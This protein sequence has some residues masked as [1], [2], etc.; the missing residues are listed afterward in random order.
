MD[1]HPKFSTWLAAAQI[2]PGNES[3]RKY[4]AG[5]SEFAVDRATIISLTRVA[6]RLEPEPAFEAKLVAAIHAQDAAFVP[7]PIVLAA[8]AATRL[9]ITLDQE[10]EPLDTLAALAIVCASES[11]H[12]Q[13]LFLDDLSATAESVVHFRSEHRGDWDYLRTGAT[14]DGAEEIEVLRRVVAVTA[15][16]ANILWWIFGETSRD[17]KRRF[18]ALS[19]ELIPFVAGK[20]LA[21][22]TVLI[23]GPLAIGAFADRVWRHGRATLTEQLSV[24]ASIASLPT[25]WRDKLV[26]R[27]KDKPVL[28]LAPIAKAITASAMANGTQWP[29]A[30]TKSTGWQK[31]QKFSSVQLALLTYR[32]SLLL[33]AWNQSAS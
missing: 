18:E 20:E 28:A 27:W 4:W 19:D 24:S 8:L 15:E 6:F 26:A 11:G 3:V 12:K 25:N 10:D 16:E 21:D 5:I 14:E 31:G 22:L 2:T 9:S 30:F 29:V 17:E 23:P 32:E 33:K 1:I 7:G 13:Q